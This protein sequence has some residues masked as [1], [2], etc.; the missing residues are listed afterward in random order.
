MRI[1]EVIRGIQTF[2]ARVR[3]SVAGLGSSTCD[4]SVECGSAVQARLL[5]ARCYGA[6]NVLSIRSVLSESDQ[7]VVTPSANII[8]TIK[9]RPCIKRK[10][11]PLTAQQAMKKSIADVKR[12]A[13]KQERKTKAINRV[14][15]AQS[16]LADIN[17]GT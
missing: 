6:E 3:V 10:I 4:V 15:D 7:P 8:P 11:K 12:A 14:R 17:R 13:K 1:D 9:P 2:V 5:V 16:M